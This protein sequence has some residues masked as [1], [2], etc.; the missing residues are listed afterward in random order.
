MLIFLTLRGTALIFQIRKYVG[1]DISWW[2]WEKGILKLA[3]KLR[4]VNSNVFVLL[5]KID[6]LVEYNKINGRILSGESKRL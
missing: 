4:S 6:V 1:T 5:N 2:L 3:Q